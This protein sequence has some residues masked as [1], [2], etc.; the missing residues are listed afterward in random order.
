[1]GTHPSTRVSAT[2]VDD[3]WQ[4]VSSPPTAATSTSELAHHKGFAGSINRGTNLTPNRSLLG[5]SLS[6]WVV[7]EMPRQNEI[8]LRE[9]EEFWE[10]IEHLRKENE[11]LR[12]GTPPGDRSML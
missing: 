7:T 5:G 12:N 9:N 8:L 10:E 2:H 6:S 3:W 11:E 1:M 4:P